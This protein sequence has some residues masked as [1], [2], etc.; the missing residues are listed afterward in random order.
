MFLDIPLY[1]TG[2]IT[3]VEFCTAL[4]ADGDTYSGPEVGLG[5]VPP[6]SGV[7]Q[8][9]VVVHRLAEFLFATEI[10]LSCLNRCVPK[11]KLNLLKFSACQMA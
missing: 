10:A 9:E 11:Q 7:F 2:V 8:S 4:C 5:A 1:R 3:C 6:G